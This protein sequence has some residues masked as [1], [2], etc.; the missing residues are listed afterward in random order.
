MAYPNQ[1]PEQKA[2]DNIDRMLG[3][4]G[5][6]VQDKKH[7]D[8]HAGLGVAIKEYQTES[9]PEDYVLFVD[10]QPVGIVEAKKEEEG[11]YNRQ[12]L[13]VTTSNNQLDFVQHIR[14]MLKT[15]GQ[16]A[17]VVPDNVLFEGGAGE[18]VRKKLL[19]DTD[20][21]TILRLPTG[22]FYAQGVKANVLFFDNK[23]AGPDP[24][25]KK[26]WDYDYR[27]NIHHTLKKKNHAA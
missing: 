10:R 17:V 9:G 7:I 11:F 1:N 21:H 23:P 15:T 26:V 25:T 20:L 13:W 4:E 24:W 19:Q 14:M 6:V 5:W 2:R 27:I 8:F 22:I 18:T 16:A 3:E 12:D